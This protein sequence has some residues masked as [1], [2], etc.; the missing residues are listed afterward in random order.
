MHVLSFTVSGLSA[1]APSFAEKNPT[2]NPSYTEQAPATPP[3]ESHIQ[4]KI[5]MGPS[6]YFFGSGCEV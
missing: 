6:S 5:R 3:R 1:D 2:S 4:G